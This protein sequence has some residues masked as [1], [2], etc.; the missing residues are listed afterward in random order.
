RIHPGGRG[1]ARGR[2]PRAAQDPLHLAGQVRAVRPRAGQQRTRRRLAQAH[3]VSAARTFP[4][5]KE[6][7]MKRT[8][9]LVLAVAA[10]LPLSA[11]AH[12]QWIIPSQAVVNGGDVWVTFD[13]AISNQ[14]F[15]PDHV[16]MRLDNVTAT[17]PDGSTVELHR[18][19]EH[20]SE[21]QSRE[22]LV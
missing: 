16:P 15:F 18:S 17:A 12:K 13:G 10:L 20:T 1:R 14:L 21:L 8:S 4:S 5:F 7:S 2:R 22:N 19:E 6:S 11:A 3:A 9:L